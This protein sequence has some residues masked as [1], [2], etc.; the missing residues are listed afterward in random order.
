MICRIYD[1]L[2]QV[3]LSRGSK[4]LHFVRSE[5]RFSCFKPYLCLNIK[6][7]ITFKVKDDKLTIAATYVIGLIFKHGQVSENALKAWF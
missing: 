1:I 5:P 4:N 6:F 2:K 7:P 3:F